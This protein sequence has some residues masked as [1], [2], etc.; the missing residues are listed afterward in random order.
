MEWAENFF[1]KF[2]FTVFAA[3]KY[4]IAGG[5]INERAAAMPHFSSNEERKQPYHLETDR[6]I[7][8]QTEQ[9]SSNTCLHFERCFRK[10]KKSVS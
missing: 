4:G 6:Q 9:A 10:R 5:K 7:F 2:F 3:L 1:W 8:S